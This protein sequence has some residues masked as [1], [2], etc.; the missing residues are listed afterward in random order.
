MENNKFS[1]IMMEEARSARIGKNNIH[2][3]IISFLFSRTNGRLGRYE[4]RRRGTEE[5]K[6][7][8]II[9]N[10]CSFWSF[11]LSTISEL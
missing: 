5:K 3:I 4:E 9:F 1:S 7:T 2:H 8:Q 6:E 11:R 10:E